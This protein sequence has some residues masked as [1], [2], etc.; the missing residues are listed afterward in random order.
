MSRG[1][2]RRVPKRAISRTQVGDAALSL[3]Y[4][5]A[6]FSPYFGYATVEQISGY[7]SPTYPPML[8]CPLG[9]PCGRSSSVAW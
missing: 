3:L 6:R 9:A 2:A 4:D 8:R 7:G 5:I 1:Y